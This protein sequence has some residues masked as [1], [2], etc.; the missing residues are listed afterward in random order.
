MLG[1][2]PHTVHRR[3]AKIT[4]C[5]SICT[6][7]LP[8]YQE[9]VAHSGRDG[10]LQIEPAWPLPSCLP[11]HLALAASPTA[12]AQRIGYP[13]RHQSS[14]SPASVPTINI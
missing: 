2:S 12:P 11:P 7:I 8:S 3:N 13:C 6:R 5:S 1:L 9:P 4:I 10:S 14:L